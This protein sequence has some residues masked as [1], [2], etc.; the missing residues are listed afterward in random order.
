MALWFGD[1]EKLLVSITTR[2]P[3]PLAAGNGISIDIITTAFEPVFNAKPCPFLR[4]LPFKV[5]KCTRP[6]VQVDVQ[7]GPGICSLQVDVVGWI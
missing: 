4:T 7:K 1:G 2:V 5:I 3:I 6:Y